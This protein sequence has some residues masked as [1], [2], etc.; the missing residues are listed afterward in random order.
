LIDA[1]QETDRA[2]AQA[3]LIKRQQNQT[4]SRAEAAA[5]DRVQQAQ[6]AE[7][8]KAIKPKMFRALCDGMQH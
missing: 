2:L 6:L 4:P 8:L 7:S 3:A 1:I 5:L